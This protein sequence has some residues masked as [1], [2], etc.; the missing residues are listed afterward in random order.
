MRWFHR[1]GGGGTSENRTGVKFSFSW[2]GLSLPFT[3]SIT[4][5]VVL[6][7]FVAGGLLGMGGDLSLQEFS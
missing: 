3:L 2:E 5:L 4:C 1:E 6:F 7:C